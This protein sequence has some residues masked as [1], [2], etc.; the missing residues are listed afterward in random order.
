MNEQ[1]ENIEDINPKALEFQRK[2]QDIEKAIEVYESDLTIVILG[3]KVKT[4]IMED[5]MDELKKHRLYAIILR[6]VSEGIEISDGTAE[7]SV[8]SESDVI[9]MIDGEKNKPA[10]GLVSEVTIISLSPNYQSKTILMVDETQKS[11][12]DIMDIKQYYVYFQSI[13]FYKNDEESVKKSV[14]LVR[15]RC[16][17]LAENSRRE[18]GNKT[19]NSK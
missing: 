3:E 18:W 12:D 4:C 1:Q 19:F 8:I 9:L 2:L 5:I 7:E 10:A 13:Y 15:K 6:P 16:R 17:Q 14:A 11:F